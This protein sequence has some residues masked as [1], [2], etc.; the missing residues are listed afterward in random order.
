[1]IHVSRCT[2]LRHRRRLRRTDRSGG[3]GT[4]QGTGQDAGQGDLASLT[5][6]MG[7]ADIGDL[8]GSSELGDLFRI[9]PTDTRTGGVQLAANDTPDDPIRPRNPTDPI[10]E[11]APLV[12]PAPKIPQQWPATTAERMSFV[13]DAAEWV[14]RNMA[15]RSPAVD[16]FF[17]AA[18]QIKEINALTDA[19]KSAN[20]PAKTLEELQEPIGTKSQSGYQDH[21][22]AEEAAAR[23]AG[24]T[25]SLI[26]SRENRARIPVLKHIEITRY[27]STKV[28][29]EDGTRISPREK[30]RGEDFETRHQ[31]G[32]DILRKYGVLK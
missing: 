4:A 28:E 3:A 5:Q 18:K 32:L 27:Y 2:T 25:E 11:A 20:D 12:D 6:P 15:R 17:G 22:I 30:L 9:K 21:H 29:Q 19:I 10:R 24:D 14:A 16:A 7:N 31:F 8:S 23:D 13:R 26:Q 1:V